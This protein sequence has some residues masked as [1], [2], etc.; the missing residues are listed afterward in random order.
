MKQHGQIDFKLLHK[1][2]LDVMQWLFLQQIAF[3]S[4]GN[5]SRKINGWVIAKQKTI[6]DHLGISDRT[7]RTYI[8]LLSENGWLE[9]DGTSKMIKTS[10][11]WHDL[12]SWKKDDEAENSSKESG[13]NFQSEAEN[14]SAPTMKGEIEERVEVKKPS[15]KEFE[16]QFCN[17][18]KNSLSVKCLDCEFIDKLSA[19]SNFE[20]I[21]KEIVCIKPEIEIVKD[22]ECTPASNFE[23]FWL[24]YPRKEGKGKARMAYYKAIEK[25]LKW[26]ILE[27]IEK[28]KQTE[29]WQKD[30]GK[31]I[32]HAANWLDGERWLDEVKQ[33]PNNADMLEAVR[34]WNPT[35]EEDAS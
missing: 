13:N 29:A 2:G 34:N 35:N 31:Y 24:A 12:Q 28:Q 27:A 25:T 18:C 7:I 4:N 16:N 10:Q 21:T 1:S 11:K 9:K 15:K 19:G 32:P 30:N 6:A 20:N 8:N 33:E 23:Q 22:Q 17:I 26:D 5:A 3:L 14:S